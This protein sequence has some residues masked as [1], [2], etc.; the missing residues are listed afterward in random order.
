MDQFSKMK[1]NGMEYSRPVYLEVNLQQLKSNLNAIRA[2][3]G[4]A[5]VMVMVK[6]N[7]YG[8][9]VDGVA[10]FIEPDVDYFGVALLE[11]GIH[12][13]ELG[14]HKPILVAGGA[15]PEH[16][17]HYAKYDLTLTG[18]SVSLLD[19][20]ENES[21]KHGKSIKVH[22]KIDTGMERLGVHE[23]DARGLIEKAA[24]CSH[25]KVEGIFTHLANSEIVDRRYSNIQLERFQSVLQLYS[26]INLPV[27]SIKHVCNSGGIVNLPNAYYDMVRTGI[28]FYGVY[29]G[30]GLKRSI[31]VKPALRWHAQVSYSKR[32]PAGRPVSYGS[33]WQPESE[34]RIITIPCGYGDG[35]FRRLS[36][37]SVVMI[38]G[39][40]YPQVG[41]VCMDQF[42]VDV[43]NDQV[44]PG[45]DVVL[46]GD[47]I[48]AEEFADWVGT[49][50]YEVLTNINTRVPRVYL[51]EGW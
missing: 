33:M 3:V 9:G 19:A 35:Y 2:F 23:F 51:K 14:I 16:I 1:A 41:R 46:L 34:T 42:M 15:L 24:A 31:D 30:R 36:N 49:N 48:L 21:V 4:N 44:H 29:P 18:A 47:G 5:K 39:K 22:L 10:P 27:P 40:K 32:I 17:Q 25:I 20:A 26:S 50:E 13:R 28:L 6:A 43:G 12:L 7:A 38:S 8:H 37:Q 45:Q 11:E